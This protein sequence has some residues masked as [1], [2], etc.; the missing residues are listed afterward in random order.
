LQLVS[1]PLAFFCR[2][3]SISKRDDA[4]SIRMFINR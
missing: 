1:L 2:V 4:R 3:W